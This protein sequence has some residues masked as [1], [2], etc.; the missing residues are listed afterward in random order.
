M[1][2]LVFDSI[3]DKEPPLFTESGFNFFFGGDELF[4]KYKPVLGQ[5]ETVQVRTKF[6][7]VEVVNIA[8]IKFE[9]ELFRNKHFSFVGN[10]EGGT[11]ATA[12][13]NGIDDRQY[14]ITRITP[15]GTDTHSYFVN[16]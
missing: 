15:Y 8:G 7:V 9:T 16:T 12:E 2:A 6:K 14:K 4:V 11:R 3:I 5:E 10:Y 1:Q 13:L